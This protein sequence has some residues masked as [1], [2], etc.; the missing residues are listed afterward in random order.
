MD[1]QTLQ[2]AQIFTFFVCIVTICFST[3]TLK[4]VKWKEA[5]NVRRGP[6]IHTMMALAIIC[7]AL[8]C[9]GYLLMLYDPC[10]SN[11]VCYQLV[12][13]L[14]ALGD[15]VGSAATG[16]AF[17]LRLRAMNTTNEPTSNWLFLLGIMPIAYI[18][19]DVCFILS[20]F[21]VISL[22]QLWTNS[23]GFGLALEANLVCLHLL[24]IYRLYSLRF[25][26]RTIGRQTTSKGQPS[27]ATNMSAE[28]IKALE[29]EGLTLVAAIA[30]EIVVAIVCI[31]YSEH[32]PTGLIGTVICIFIWAVDMYL[33]CAIDSYVTNLIESSGGVSGR[34]SVSAQSQTPTLTMGGVGGRPILSTARASVCRSGGTGDSIET[35]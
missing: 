20:T 22:A 3:R 11:P 32:D 2:D 25:S 7:V 24:M 8:C 1:S 21:G 27:G 31:V 5:F 33:F 34:S 15:G 28:K 9:T 13:F 17:L 6:Q 14:Y 19:N 4:S 10:Y 18:A 12:N 35:A 26:I 23:V 29:R 16:W 30:A